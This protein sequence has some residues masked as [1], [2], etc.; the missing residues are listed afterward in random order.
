MLLSDDD[1]DRD[2]EQREQQ[3]R[4]REAGLDRDVEKEDQ[5]PD[6]HR[7]AVPD[8]RPDARQPPRVAGRDTSLSVAS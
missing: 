1:E 4:E 5:E 2:R 3:R 8:R 6:E 7:A